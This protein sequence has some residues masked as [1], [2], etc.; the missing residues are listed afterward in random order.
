ME[1]NKAG[2]RIVNAMT[3]LAHTHGFRTLTF[4]TTLLPAVYVPKRGSK[5][6]INSKCLTLSGKMNQFLKRMNFKPLPD[7]LDP[8]GA[9]RAMPWE[10]DGL[11]AEVTL[12]GKEGSYFRLYFN[13]EDT[14]TH[15]KHVEPVEIDL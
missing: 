6:Q 5:S 4:K 13:L 14:T 11:R 1:I 12:L 15:V 2:L 3:N 10:L 8:H 9:Y 7:E